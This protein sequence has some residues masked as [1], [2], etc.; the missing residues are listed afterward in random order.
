MKKC[1]TQFILSILLTA[2]GVIQNSAWADRAI[3]G[4]R[5]L[6]DPAVL[7]HDGEVYFY[8]SNDNEN[9]LE[10][11]YAMKSLVCVSSRDLKNWTDHGEVFEVTKDAPW[12]SRSWAP[13]VIE[14][15]GKIF[16]YF[17]NGGGGI[18]VASSD[19]PTGPFKEPL[20]HELVSWSTPGAGGPNMWLFDPA[21]FIDDD[22]Q[23]YLYFGGNGDNNVRVIKLNRDM[24][25][26]SGEAQPMTAPAFFEA[27]WM[28][29]YQGT[30]YFSYSTN[31]SNEMRIDY[32]TSANPTKDFVYRGVVA[33][34]PPNNHNNN[35]AGIFEFK[36]RWFF[37]YH[38]R[39]VATKAGIPTAFKRN[40]GLEELFFNED[41]S[42]REIEFTHDGLV[43]LENLNPLV[44]VE[45]ET[46]ADQSG[47]KTEKRSEGGMAV[48]EISNGDWIRVRGVDFGSGV[49]SFTTRVAAAGCGS[50]QLRLDSATGP[51]I[52]S[53]MVQSTG[54]LQS[55]T[56]VSAE[57]DGRIA[58]GVHDLYFV[59]VDASKGNFL[60]MD[61]WQFR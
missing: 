58:L 26:V 57:V 9:A 43:Q 55:W 27:S 18:G 31:P 23:A 36:G 61:W 14:R 19:S 45:A 22:G 29:K 25:S 15:D 30:Y 48:T 20:G 21:A 44:R 34:Q 59:F 38:D 41:K 53:C 33:S 11:G 24:I 32:M 8:C 56:D 12:A 50:I 47:I 7:V 6:A 60:S 42:I 17:G 54:G 39:E 16:L 1:V 52:G 28:N 3:V 51:V 13:S 10:G 37:V 40:L 35:H 4:Y 49:T 46:M 2:G 5:F